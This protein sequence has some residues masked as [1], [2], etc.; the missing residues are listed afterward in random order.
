[1]VICE[2]YDLEL[3]PPHSHLWVS[4]TVQWEPAEDAA[5][6]ESTPNFIHPVVVKGHPGRPLP[7][8]ITGLNILPEV[9]SGHILESPIWVPAP[10]IPG[11]IAEQTQRGCKN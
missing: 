1:L 11:S 6:L 4:H 7:F 10:S 9:V 8:D 5:S 2:P 3:A